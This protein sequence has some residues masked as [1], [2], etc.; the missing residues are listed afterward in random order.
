MRK[1]IDGEPEAYT[2][3]YPY[4]GFT[5]F[6]NKGFRSYLKTGCMKITLQ[7]SLP[8]YSLFLSNPS[9]G[10][11]SINS[12]MCHSQKPLVLMY[13]MCNQLTVVPRADQGPRL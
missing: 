6:S 2:I 7:S 10:V 12:T 11:A 9:P 8:T 1:G 13:E 4:C 3:T 5:E